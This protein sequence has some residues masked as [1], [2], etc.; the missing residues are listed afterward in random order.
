MTHNQLISDLWKSQGIINPYTVIALQADHEYA[1]F[2]T[3]K[4]MEMN[5]CIDKMFKK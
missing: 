3:G 5:F 1:F 2:R 4:D